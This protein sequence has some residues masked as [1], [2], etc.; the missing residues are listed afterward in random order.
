MAAPDSIL[1]PPL[2]AESSLTAIEADAIDFFVRIANIVGVSKSVGAIYGLL[3][4]SPSPVPAEYIR[5][6]LRVS[7]GS[8]SQGL[9]LLA[10][11]GAVN[12]AYVPGDRRDCYV[13]ETA[14]RR[15]TGGFFRVYVAP[16]LSDQDGR[17]ARLGELL[18]ELPPSKRSLMEK[19][20]E[21][22]REWRRKAGAVLPLMMDKLDEEEPLTAR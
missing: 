2:H 13:A 7:S 15:I 19:R 3:F 14:L 22:L 21:T 16:K 4:A 1:A 12:V 5:E 6:K 17:L 9:R 18:D 8:T 10:S 20:V 11:I